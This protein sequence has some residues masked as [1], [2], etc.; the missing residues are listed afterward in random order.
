[1]KNPGFNISG[2]FMFQKCLPLP[3][4]L[5]KAE[6]HRLGERSFLISG[7]L[8][9]LSQPSRPEKNFPRPESGQGVGVFSENGNEAH[10]ILN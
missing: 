6:L 4:P 10:L 7:L 8:G 3:Q 9:W 1:M 5:P 2:F